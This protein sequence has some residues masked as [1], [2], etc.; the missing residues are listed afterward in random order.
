MV[1]SGCCIDHPRTLEEGSRAKRV[2]RPVPYRA[3][4]I[5][6]A[7]SSRGMKAICFLSADHRVV[8]SRYFLDKET[9]RLTSNNG[10]HIEVSLWNT[11]WTP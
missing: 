9:A 6:I 1:D 4:P 11:L 8:N 7:T 2:Q 5:L 3:R 10:L